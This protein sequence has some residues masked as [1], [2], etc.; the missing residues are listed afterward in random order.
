MYAEP[1]H[2]LVFSHLVC[3]CNLRPFATAAL[4]NCQFGL[5]Q[6]PKSSTSNKVQSDNCVTASSSQNI[7]ELF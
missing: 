7:S 4:G 6:K 2:K 1:T 5:Y 3:M